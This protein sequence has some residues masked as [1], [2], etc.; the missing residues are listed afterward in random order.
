MESGLPGGIRLRGAPAVR[1]GDE[2]LYALAADL[3]CDAQCLD[4]SR[5]GGHVAAKAGHS[6]LI[7]IETRT[8]AA[9]AASHRRRDWPAGWKGCLLLRG[10]LPLPALLGSRA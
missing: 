1:I 10:A 4:R 7:F 8:S 5:S 9:V 6:H 3:A 2:D